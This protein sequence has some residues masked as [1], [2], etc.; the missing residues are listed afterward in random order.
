MNPKFLILPLLALS[1]LCASSQKAVAFEALSAD[2]TTRFWTDS[3]GKFVYKTKSY[4]SYIY[5]TVI[6]PKSQ[7]Q[8][9]VASFRDFNATSRE[10]CGGQNGQ[11]SNPCTVPPHLPAR[12]QPAAK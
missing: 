2:G 1:L 9:T 12:I 4:G 7:G 11:F 6:N 10:V 8:K 5:G 3:E